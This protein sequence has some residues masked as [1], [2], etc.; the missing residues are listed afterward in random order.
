MVST[1][2]FNSVNGVKVVSGSTP[3][4]LS[5]RSIFK[6]LIRSS[7]LL[8]SNPVLPL[9][10]IRISETYVVS[11]ISVVDSDSATKA[12]CFFYFLLFISRVLACK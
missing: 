12:I 10:I 8:L 9:V 2:V 4:F 11:R 3:I 5:E 7:S 1:L 6:L